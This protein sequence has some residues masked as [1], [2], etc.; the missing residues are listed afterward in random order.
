M[1]IVA[2]SNTEIKATSKLGRQY[3]DYHPSL[4]ND[5]FL[6]Y[7]SDSLEVDDEMKKTI[8]TLKEEVRKILV[9]MKEPIKKAEVIESIQCLGLSYH[10]EPEIDEMLKQIHNGYVE[11]NEI[12]HIEDLHYLALL[13]KLLR[14]HEYRVPPDVFNKFKDEKGN[15][16][17]TLT[18]DVEGMITLYE[19]CYMSIHGE[20]I[21]D[22]ALTF[23]TNH[24]RSITIHESSSFVAAKL[25][26]VLKQCTYRGTP[27][28]EARKYLSIYHLHPSCNEVLLT[29]AKLDFN[30]LQKL[31]QKEIGNLCKWWNSLDV[32]RNLPYTRNR[33]VESYFWSL[34]ACSEP[35]YSKGRSITTKAICLITMIDD[36]F[37]IYGTINELELFTSAI[38]RWDISCM[39]DL[40][41][42]MK[43][44]YKEIWN[45]F[46]EIDDEVKGQEGRS[47]YNV[48][49]LIKD[50]KSIVEAFMAEARWLDRNKIPTVEEY[51]NVSTVTICTALMSMS[52]F[53]CMGD[54][55]VTEDIFKW[56]RSQPKI[57]QATNVI[58]R[59]MND[60]VSRE[61]E[62]KKEHVASSVECCMKE[63]GVT[64]LEAV[65][66][67]R[68]MIKNAWKDI[69]EE[70]LKPTQV[71]IPFLM[72]V[73]NY[74]RSFNV[75]YRDV[76]TYTH[77]EGTMKEFI[78]Q[79]F[80]DPVPI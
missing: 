17:E 50:F 44:I 18:S 63:Q 67:L 71:P 11:N 57:I 36:T 79:L 3:T 52:H 1:S 45:M 2:P 41:G 78:S 31:H 73:L 43:L 38:E 6:K 51:L 59:L 56:A 5:Y 80:V 39:D 62:Q 72:I 69:N 24:L 23:T 27:R 58:G 60:I 8:E 16:R 30:A 61:F 20:D 35:Q 10:F 66:E 9:S 74:A 12:S 29:L 76:D 4:W 34:A 33:L 37:D 13:F 15:F 28:L 40:P 77:S 48:D 49:Y 7:A 26:N 55:F 32:P 70:C 14:Q 21:L 65:D 75:I 25:N 54:I 22:Q 42:Y 64:R 53:I 46:G 68:K 19:A 47:S